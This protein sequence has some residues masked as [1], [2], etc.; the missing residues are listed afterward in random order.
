MCYHAVLAAL[1]NCVSPESYMLAN[2]THSVESGDLDARGF[3]VFV[4]LLV[5]FSVW[6]RKM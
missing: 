5:T 4:I 6:F 2:S 3:R 1:G